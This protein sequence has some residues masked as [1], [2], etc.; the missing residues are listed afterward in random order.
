MLRFVL[1]LALLIL[2]FGPAQAHH[3]REFRIKH[4]WYVPECERVWW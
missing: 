4:L 3:R 2:L 1:S